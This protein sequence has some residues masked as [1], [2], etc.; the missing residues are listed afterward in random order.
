MTKPAR[1]D[2]GTDFTPA[3]PA[4]NRLVLTAPELERRLDEREAA[5]YARGFDEGAG[6]EAASTIARL[7]QTLARMA[8]QFADWDERLTRRQQESE[9]DA[10]RLA[11]LLAQ[12]LAGR[13]RAMDALVAIEEAFLGLLLDLRQETEVAVALAPELAGEAEERLSAIC[14]DRLAS[15]RLRILPDASLPPGDCRIEWSGGGLVRCA[16]E[17][18][19]RL[20][21]IV[22]R[23]LPS[24][25]APEVLP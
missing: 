25:P 9:A 15:F 23:T 3:S 16:A 2:F 7:N 17:T 20:T 22:E 19:A 6:A 21:D 8:D 18:E 5:G 14:R 4:D 24:V 11:L 10:A 1:F 13:L 12:K